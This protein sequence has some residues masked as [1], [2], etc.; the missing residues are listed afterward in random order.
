MNQA[1][2]QE[3]PAVLQ[4]MSLPEGLESAEAARRRGD[5]EGALRI[6]SELRERYP[7]HPAPYLR[8][9]GILSQSS[10]FAEAEAL[11]VQGAERFPK[12]IGFAIERAWLASRRGKVDEALELWRQIRG[13]LTDHHAGYTGAAQALRDAGRI[14]EAETLLR[15]AMQRFPGEPVPPI[16]YA[17]LAHRARNWPEAA[18][19]WDE[20]RKHHPDQTVGFTAGAIA[21]RELR[22][23]DAAEALLAEALTRFPGDRGSLNEHAWLAVAQR[24][25][26]EAARRWALVRERFPDD[27]E[28]YLRGAQALSSMWRHE[29][30]EA[31][32]SDAIGRFPQDGGIAAEHAWLAYHR[33]L[34]EEAGQRFAE[35]RCR[36]PAL[37]AG[38]L[39]G[40]RVLRDQFRLAEAEAILE[41]AH[42]RFPDQPSLL[43]E[44]ARIPLFHP[45]RRERDP[46]EAMRRVE[47]LLAK[48]PLCEEAYLLG[49]R[50]L[51]ELGRPS[52]ADELAEIGIGLLPQS[53]ALAI[54]NANNARE[55]GD[56]AEAIWRYGAARQRFPEEPGGPIGLAA[57]L[58]LSGRH[59]EAEQA[60][61]EAME[62]FPGN[63]A[64]F[65]EFARI[66]VRQ[67]DWPEALT[68]WRQAQKRFPD[69]QEFAHRIF[70][71]ELR[72]TESRPTEQAPEAAGNTLTGAAAEPVADVDPRA[73]T[74]DL[75]IQFESLGGRGLGCEFGMFQREF[76]AEPLG[77]LRWADMPYD[78]IIAALESRFDGV[79][80]PEHTELFV[81][82]EHARP[83]YCTRDKRGFM[84]MRAFI[85]EDE[86]PYDRMWKQALRRLVFLKHKLIA[87]LEAGDKIFVY[88]L[89]DRNLE[90]DELERLH[91]AV[92]SYASNTLLYVRYED[93]AHPNGTVEF[94][95][96]GLMIGYMDRFKM[97]PDGQLSASPPSA[98][99]LEI[100]RNAHGLFIGSSQ[101]S[102][103]APVGSIG[104]ASVKDRPPA[105]RHTPSGSDFF[106]PKL[107]DGDYP[108][109]RDDQLRELLR[110]RAFERLYRPHPAG[111]IV[112]SHAELYDV[113][114]ETIGREAPVTVLEFGVAH[115]RSMRMLTERFSDPNARFV[116][117]DSFVGLPEPWL[118]HQVGAFSNR[119]V[120]P[121]LADLRVSFVKGWFQN[122]LPAYLDSFSFDPARRYLVHLDADLY[123]STLFVLNNLWPRLPDYYFIMDDFLQDDVAALFDFA[124]A[125]PIEL[126][127]IAQTRGGG[128][129]PM[130]GQVLGRM[131]RTEFAINVSPETEA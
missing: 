96:P 55:R 83:E 37:L 68:R 107:R 17:W 74:R 47:R 76:G 9:A 101:S 20:V 26:P 49:V 10:R 129:T 36:F 41:E 4:P 6:F 58:S 2:L 62:R 3:E 7:D 28:A 113:A 52:E 32:L 102:E 88:R 27:P 14:E 81:D 31:L 93:T 19:R 109:K 24:E 118:M 85:Y 114:A 44:H 87:D 103:T 78:G 65:A 66:A 35:L 122:S 84:F 54:E 126:A 99:W 43:C 60:L 69:E 39:G 115:G 117:F 15:E 11:L 5:Q 100:C 56:W 80:A 45:L 38:Y 12:E 73:A 123:A 116:G 77:L 120:P 131:R 112:E 21:L 121:A 128:P 51:R 90:P 71:T 16:E 1:L 50:T 22:Q 18:R 42:H 33:H 119:G 75:L 40:A 95:A 46:E 48:F 111:R 64:A 127:F 92:R 86:M 104:P 29:E 67:E 57:S 94:A 105:D 70:E 110:Q 61:R 8:A 23:F 25:W 30:A 106:R 130:P 63:S 53:A 13:T 125:Y 79:G 82:R 124:S 72:L 34:P 98:S 59:V 91:R 89:T 108:D 97:A